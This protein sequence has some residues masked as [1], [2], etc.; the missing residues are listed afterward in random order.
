MVLNIRLRAV[1]SR[2]EGLRFRGLGHLEG[3]GDLV[4]RLTMGICGVTT[5]L[6]GGYSPTL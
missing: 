2:I 5:W 4:S 6:I 3:N 1:G